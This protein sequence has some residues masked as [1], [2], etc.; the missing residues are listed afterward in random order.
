MSKLRPTAKK[1]SYKLLSE[2]PLVFDKFLPGI[3]KYTF[4]GIF[5]VPSQVNG[6]ILCFI[7]CITTLKRFCK[8]AL[9]VLQII[10]FIYIK[11]F[12]C[13]IK[14]LLFNI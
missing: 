14:I 10:Y 8:A 6:K 4:L 1:I 11:V 5:L 13:Q 2:W 7:V 3:R 9:N 12:S